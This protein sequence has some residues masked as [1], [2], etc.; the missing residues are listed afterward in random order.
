MGVQQASESGRCAERARRGAARV[1]AAVA[2]IVSSNYFETCVTNRARPRARLNEIIAQKMC[3]CSRG[4]NLV[5]S[6][7]I[8]CASEHSV[9]RCAVNMN[10]RTGVLLVSVSQTW[11][12]EISE[13][14]KSS[15]T[16][17]EP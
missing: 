4:I 5:V 13:A 15:E 6:S 3:Y 14:R 1:V 12:C 11:W 9:A 7:T 16:E 10:S 17:L 2:G 8:L